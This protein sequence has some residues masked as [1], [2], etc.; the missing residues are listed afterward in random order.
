MIQ[1]YEVIISN[2]FQKQ[3]ELKKDGVL[4]PSDGRTPRQGEFDE[5]Y[6]S[7][8]SMK[9][10]EKSKEWYD[11]TTFTHTMKNV[12]RKLKRDHGM[13]HA[14][15][16]YCKLAELFGTNPELSVNTRSKG[17]FRSLHLCEAPGAFIHAL[18]DYLP[19]TDVEWRANTLNPHYEWNDPEGMFTEDELICSFPKQWIFGKDNSG[20][21]LKTTGEEFGID[22]FDLVTADGSLVSEGPQKEMAARQIFEA[23][24][25]IALETLREGGDFIMKNY[26]LK[27]ES[28]R[29]LVA[30]CLGCFSTVRICKPSCSKPGNYEVYLVCSRFSSSL[31]SSSTLECD[32]LLFNAAKF[33]ADHQERISQFN[34]ESFNNWNPQLKS[35]ILTASRNAIEE[36]ISRFLPE[37]LSANGQATEQRTLIPWARRESSRKRE[38]ELTW[39]W[40]F[41]VPQ[42]VVFGIQQNG[43]VINSLFTPLKYRNSEFKDIFYD[44]TFKS[45]MEES[46]SYIV[47]LA[48]EEGTRNSLGYW[49]KFLLYL[50]A[51]RH[52]TF[53]LQTTRLLAQSRLSASVIGL[54]CCLYRKVQI[55]VGEMKFSNRIDQPIEVCAFLKNLAEAERKDQS[56][57]SFLSIAKLQE[58]DLYLIL[59]N[60][61]LINSRE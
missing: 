18:K 19:G 36:W 35:Y 55:A 60:F 5:L 31:A 51:F 1:T 45:I 42:D 11:H 28:M 50:C 13:S 20:D 27:T 10:G 26:T 41:T 53:V 48:F 3:F 29:A 34:Q 24:V 39:H 9:N 52:G 58:T 33:F 7:L 15:Q 21:V 44:G 37:T 32:G 59:L 46:G 16:A 56:M 30:K 4:T 6:K 47:H 17:K 12:P 14:S 43:P 57:M 54:L 2:L 22:K 8:E 61:N 40:N 49:I 23:E 38:F 25:R